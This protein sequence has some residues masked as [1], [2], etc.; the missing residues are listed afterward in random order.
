MKTLTEIEH[1]KELNGRLV[2]ALNWEKQSKWLAHFTS[3][4]LAGV[5]GL[6]AFFGVQDLVTSIELYEE[7]VALTE[8]LAE[9]EYK[10][11]QLEVDLAFAEEEIEEISWEAKAKEAVENMTEEESAEI[12]ASVKSFEEKVFDRIENDPEIQK[13]SKELEQAIF[14]VNVPEINRLTEILADKSFQVQDEVVEELNKEKK[15]GFF[16]K[17]WNK[18]TSVF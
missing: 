1:L 18:I 5:L 12:I 13:L 6:I 3:I 10:V 16:S 15:I 11:A 7:N 4:V 9:A 17:A 14:D 8:K 2:T